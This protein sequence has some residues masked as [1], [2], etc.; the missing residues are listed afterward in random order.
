MFN[1][2]IRHTTGDAILFH[3]HLFKNAGTTIEY[4]LNSNFPDAH[5][6]LEADGFRQLTPAEITGA[7]DQNPHWRALSSH[8][9]ALVMPEYPRPLIGLVFIRHPIDR[10]HSVYRY[11]RRRTDEDKIMNPSAQVAKETDFRGFVNWALDENNGYGS[12]IR[13]FQSRHILGRDDLPE[14]KRLL[15]H[16]PCVGTVE[17]LDLSLG[18]FKYSLQRYFGEMNMQYVIQNQSRSRQPELDSRIKEI[19]SLLGPELYRELLAKNASDL[20]L[21]AYAGRLLHLRH[22]KFAGHRFIDYLRNRIRKSAADPS[23]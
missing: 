21:W 17:E 11:E 2:K 6:H 22:A 10:V 23:G 16:T 8:T 1:R 5:G 14:A 9:A 4:L 7:L 12:I 15:R 20:E 13:N 3:C 19:E 18:V